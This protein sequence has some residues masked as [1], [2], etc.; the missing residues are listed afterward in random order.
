M[1]WHNGEAYFTVPFA[2]YTKVLQMGTN[3]LVA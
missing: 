1:H 2:I 3:E